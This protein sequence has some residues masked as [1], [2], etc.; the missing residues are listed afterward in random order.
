MKRTLQVPR[1][2]HRGGQAMVEYVVCAA[3]VVL[4][5]G[6]LALLLATVRESGG[7]AVDLVSSEYP[8]PQGHASMKLPIP[9]PKSRRGQTMVEY[10]IIVAIVAIGCLV[11]FGIFGDTIKKKVSGVVSSMDDEKGQLAQ[12]EADKDS[13]ELFKSLDE[14][15]KTSN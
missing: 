5:T 4:L 13:A 11:V 1:A 6:M 15:G 8:S 9:T 14:S 12:D 2:G 7:R 10:I 3:V